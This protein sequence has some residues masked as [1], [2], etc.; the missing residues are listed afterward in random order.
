[1]S[2]LVDRLRAEAAKVRCPCAPCQ[3]TAA[4]LNEAADEVADAQ[5]WRSVAEPQLA[6]LASDTCWHCH[7]GLLPAGRPHCEDCPPDGD[8]DVEGCTAPGCAAP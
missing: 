6:R 8:C 7:D 2:D 4:L 5:Q 1:M 3:G